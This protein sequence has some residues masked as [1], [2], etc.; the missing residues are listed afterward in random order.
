MRSL[1][2]TSKVFNMRLGCQPDGYQGIFFQTQK[3]LEHSKHIIKYA[4]ISDKNAPPP[5]QKSNSLSESQRYSHSSNHAIVPKEEW[6]G[7]N[8][9]KWT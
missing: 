8:V 5:L 2:D 1:L 4:L 7:T 6:I 3:D 9:L